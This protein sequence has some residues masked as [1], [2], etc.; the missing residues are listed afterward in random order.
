ML[1]M[2][3]RQNPVDLWSMIIDGSDVSECG[4]SH[5]SLKIYQSQKGN[6]RQCKVYDVIVH[7]HFAACYV[8]NSNL[9]GEVISL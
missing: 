3:A 5:P 7:G 1:N 4:I 2:K 8:L 9:P 6:K